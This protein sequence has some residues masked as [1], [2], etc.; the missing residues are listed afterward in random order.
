MKKYTKITAL[1]LAVLM[2]A[3]IMAGCG[4]STTA[5]TAAATAAAAGTEAA[6][7]ESAAT[8]KLAEIQARG[9]LIVA[10]DATW[11]PFEYIGEAGEPAGCDMELAAYIAEQLGVELEVLNIAFDSIG[12]YLTSGEADLGLA[13]ITATE[14]RKETLAFSDPYIVSEQYIV[15]RADDDSVT[16]FEDLDGK[17]IGA[18]LGTTGD[19]LV[20]D[21]INVDGIIPNAT[22]KQYK[23]LPDASLAL[24]NGELD[25]IVCDTVMAENLCASRDNA[26][27]CFAVVFE[28][29]DV[30]TDPLCVAMNKGDDELVA[31]INEIIAPVIADG[32]YG[33]WLIEHT[34]IS[35]NL[36]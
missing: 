25:A 30:T 28:N 3:G 9:K 32:T 22:E 19:F 27:K 8:G 5:A 21:S 12:A 15:V 10:T 24:I 16:Y 4:S 26:I 2:L 34:E 6:E 33:E 23:S 36:D 11:A 7:T 17:T 1:V 35:T 31:K 13:A 20:D 14:E 29:G 18:H